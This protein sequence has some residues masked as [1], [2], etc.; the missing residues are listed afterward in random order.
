MTLAVAGASFA[1]A[2]FEA[3]RYCVPALDAWSQGRELG[4][5][6]GVIAVMA[7]AFLLALALARPLSA[8]RS[9]RA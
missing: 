5:G 3:T 2:G 4:L 7:S 6:I 1:V 8:V 9:G